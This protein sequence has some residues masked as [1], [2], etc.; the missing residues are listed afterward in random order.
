MTLGARVG[1]DAFF[2]AGGTVEELELL[3]HDEPCEP[4]TVDE[5]LLECALQQAERPSECTAAQ[6][7][8]PDGVLGYAVPLADKLALVAS[9]GSITLAGGIERAATRTTFSPEGI[10]RFRLRQHRDLADVLAEVRRL[11]VAHIRF[12]DDWQPWLVSLWVMGTFLHVLFAFFGYLHITSASKRCGKSLLLE[13]LSYLCFNATRT[14]TDPSPA[15][16]FRDAERNCGT[17]L[18]DEVETLTDADRKSR[19]AL[20]A[21]LNAGFKRG[22]AVPRVMD[23]KTDCVREFSVYAPRVLASIRRLSATVADRSFRIELIRKRRDE[24][25]MRFSHRAQ[26][27]ALARLRDELH[28]VALEH[29][30]E[31]A[32]W[33]DRA[34]KLPIPDGVD[35]R[36][37]DI[38]EPLFAIAAAADAERGSGLY[39]GAMVRAAEALSGIRSDDDSDEAALVAALTALQDICQPNNG[40]AISAGSALTLFQKTDGLSWIDTNDKARSLLRRLGFRS[41]THRRERFADKD[42]PELVKATARG[43]EIKLEA[44]RDLLSRYCARV[45]PSRAS[46]SNGHNESVRF[47]P[48]V[49]PV[50]DGE[51]AE[52][53]QATKK[54]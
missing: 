52:Q 53:I 22:A 14:A 31:I 7:L 54:P 32:A 33:Y 4:V 19:A 6:H 1:F 34:E 37:R 36:L 21:M 9:D 26:A 38:L 5:L 24:R 51:N 44:V 23:A 17:Q 30:R 50:E 29:A 40:I 41:G 2:A 43:Y 35:D 27:R 10:R 48:H 11:L 45:E 49:T 25:L 13:L 39:V 46:Q 20:M 42:R 16:V 15:F 8:R 3:A 18:L 12:G 47:T 28:L